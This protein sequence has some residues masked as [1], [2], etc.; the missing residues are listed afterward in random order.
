MSDHTAPRPLGS[1]Q[2][3]FVSFFVFWIDVSKHDEAF[4]V[5][6]QS[7]VAQCMPVHLL[8]HSDHSVVIHHVLS[9]SSG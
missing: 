4:L 7:G 6:E 8:S 5:I 2:E 9:I 3:C 1:D